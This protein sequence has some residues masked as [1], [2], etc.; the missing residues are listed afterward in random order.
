MENEKINIPKWFWFVTIF[1]LLWNIM[2]VLSFL[3]HTFITEEALAELPE[4]ER[5]L[6]GDYPVWTTIVFAIAVLTGL[7]G[8]IGL[9]LRKR[10]SKTAFVISLLAII[11]QM[12]HNVFFTRSIEVYGTIQAVTMPILVVAFGIFLVWFAD[13]CNKR[14]WL[15]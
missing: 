12:I 9:V 11:P 1:F 2:G 14:G 8:A 6:Y 7:M 10:W 5:A 3:G 15:N 13:S 4:N